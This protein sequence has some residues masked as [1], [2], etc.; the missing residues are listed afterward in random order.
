MRLLVVTDLHAE[1]EALFRIRSRL[2]SE[3]FD[4][5]VILGDITHNGPVS[6]AEEAISTFT[7]AGV[8]V[9]G[10]MGNMDPPGVLELLESTGV[11]IH[12]KRAELGAGWYIAGFGGSPARGAHTPTEF[13]D[14][15][16]YT[17]LKGLG[18]DQRTIIATH[19]PPE[20]VGGFDITHHGVSIGSGGLRRLMEEAKPAAVLCGHVHEREGIKPFGGTLVVKVAPAYEGRAAVVE[21]EKDIKA[22]LVDL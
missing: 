3:R 5:L 4:A 21:L 15:E 9:F 6:F 7:S 20:G 1:D 11:S 8:R 14:D 13:S 18:I 10:V 2:S 19:A 17:R 12:G 16:I 22:R